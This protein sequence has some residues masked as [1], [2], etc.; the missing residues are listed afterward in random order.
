MGSADAVKLVDKLR[1]AKVSAEIMSLG[2]EKP[3]EKK[4]EKKEE[5]KDEKKIECIP[6]CYCNCKPCY[7]GYKPPY[8]CPP[9]YGNPP[10]VYVEQYPQG[11]CVIS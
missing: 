9:P 6:I 2:P 5:K 11:N 8:I 7:C 10:F 1:K 4:E 3:P